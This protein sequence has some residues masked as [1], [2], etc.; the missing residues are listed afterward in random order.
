MG[1]LIQTTRIDPKEFE[2]V[3]WQK[4]NEY[5]LDTELRGKAKVEFQKTKL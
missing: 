1:T 2:K 5:Y 4:G 3:D